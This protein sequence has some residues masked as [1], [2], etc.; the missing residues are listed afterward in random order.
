MVIAQA[1]FDLV[2]FYSYLQ[3]TVESIQQL[4]NS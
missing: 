3:P 1:L 4:Y 2:H